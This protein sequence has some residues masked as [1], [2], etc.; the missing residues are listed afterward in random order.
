MLSSYGVV[1]K[2]WWAYFRGKYFR[3]ERKRSLEVKIDYGI[4]E[5][6]PE[7]KL[8]SNRKS[9]ESVVNDLRFS[10]KATYPSNP[11]ASFFP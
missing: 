3:K 10:F 6:S 7:K 1:P 9:T 11:S 2:W 8:A 5:Q 4:Y